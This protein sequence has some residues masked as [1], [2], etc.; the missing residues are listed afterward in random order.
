MTQKNYYNQGAHCFGEDQIPIPIAI[1]YEVWA[2]QNKQWGQKHKRQFTGM[3]PAKK[4]KTKTETSQPKEYEFPACLRSI[5]PSSVAIT[6]H[7]KPGSKLSSITGIFFLSFLLFFVGKWATKRSDVDEI[8]SQ[9]LG[10][11]RSRLYQLS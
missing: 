7:A 3:A 4:G 11:T 9:V 2:N 5:S 10:T 6:I 8:R 1:E